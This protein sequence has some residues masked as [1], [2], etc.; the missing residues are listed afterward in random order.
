MFSGGI[1]KDY[2]MT[3]LETSFMWIFL[4][5]VLPRTGLGDSNGERWQRFVVNARGVLCS[6]ETVFLACWSFFVN[7]PVILLNCF[8]VFLIMCSLSPVRF[9]YDREFIRKE[10]SI[11]IRL[12]SQC[13]KYSNSEVHR[14]FDPWTGQLFV[15]VFGNVFF[16]KYELISA[17]SPHNLTKITIVQ[18]ILTTCSAQWQSN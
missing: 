12:M 14:G 1:S 6:E 11:N 8:L 17:Y 5:S 9:V 13:Y 2:L 18:C 10:S 16:F 7:I 3:G 4:R 15:N